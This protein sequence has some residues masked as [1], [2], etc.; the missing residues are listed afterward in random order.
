MGIAV[1]TGASAGIGRATALAFAA[2]GSDVA[3]LSR[4][5]ERLT[6]LQNEIEARGRKAL[7]L[8]LDVADPA[9]IAS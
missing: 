6:R 8:P 7:A 4:N 3:L 9:A 1:V 5:P 2:E